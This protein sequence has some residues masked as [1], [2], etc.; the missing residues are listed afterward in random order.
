MDPDS[1]WPIIFLALLL[2]VYSLIAAAKEA[3]VSVRKSRRLQLIEEGVPTAHIIEG[4]NRTKTSLSAAEQTTLKIIQILIFI[5]T[6]STYTVPLRDLISTDSTLI[7]TL[8]IIT[9]DVAIILFFGELLPREIA[10]NFPEFFALRLVYPLHYLSFITAPLARI[11]GTVGLI[12]STDADSDESDYDPDLVTEEDL[13]TYLDASEEGGALNENE[14]EMIYSIFNLDDTLAREIM[15]PRIDMVAIEADVS[16]MDAV[17][18][19]LQDGHSRLPVYV[20]N[21]DNIIGILYAKDLLAHWRNGGK[22]RSVYG[23]EREAYFVPESKPVSELLR[24]MQERKV[25]IAMVVD[26]YGGVAGLVT[27]EDIMEEIVGEIQDE[28][29]REE[30]FMEQISENEFLFSARMDLDDINDVM[31]IN[32]PTDESDTLGGLIYTT[33]GGVPE[34]G[35]SVTID[36]LVLTVLEIHGRRIKIVKIQ[37]QDQ[38]KQSPGGGASVS[39]NGQQDSAKYIGKTSGAVSSSSS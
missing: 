21:I 23:L 14:R 13:R 31:S 1:S 36:D 19:I 16:V 29:D 27:I 2:I 18:V 12:F 26:E 22:A 37:R 33:L 34:V 35:D 20:D 17:G 9:I 28:Y 32:L 6:L 4:L 24:E 11:I 8:I 25:Q 39:F 5:I 10:R 3:V 30:F 15:V 7:S 38:N